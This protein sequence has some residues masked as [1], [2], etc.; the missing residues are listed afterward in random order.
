MAKVIALAAW[1][2]FTPVS[3]FAQEISDSL[4]SFS[5]A[6]P[7]AVIHVKPSE[8][9]YSPYNGQKI[10]FGII[11][12]NK[13]CYI[14]VKAALPAGAEYI[15]SIDNTSIDSVLLFRLTGNTWQA[16]YT[17]G[18]LVPYDRNRKYVWHTI[19]LSPVEGRTC[20]LAAFH[21]QGK[22]INVGYKIMKASDLDKRYAGFDRLI[23]FYMGGIFL[24]L[25]AVVYGWFVFRNTVLPYYALYIL[26]VTAWI[27]AHYGYLYPMLYPRFPV[28]NGI[29]KP[30]SISCG[31][32]FFSMLLR[33]LFRQ[34]L[35]KDEVSRS[36]LKYIMWLGVMMPV[37]LIAYLVLP[38]EAYMPA[39]FN[40]GWH[41]YFAV[42]F[43]CILLVLTR[44][45]EKDATARLFALAMGIMAA[46]AIQQVLSNAGFFY[47]YMLNE[48]GMLLASM[49]EILVLTF[50]TFRNIWEEKKRISMQ[51]VQLQ[52][53][54]S[55]ALEQLVTV[56][57]NERKRI[58]GEL[59]DSIGPM[60]AAIK[61]NFQRA[62]KAKAPN[63]PDALVA[64]TE[65][66]IDSSMA[67][68]RNISHQLMPKGL[69]AKG[70]AASLSEYIGNIREVYH[71]P[72]D[73]KHNITVA[74]PPDAQLNV[75]RI[76]SELT[77]N[78]AK[79]GRASCISVFLE[80][81]DGA[82]IATVA[83]DGRGFDPGQVNGSSLGLKNIASRVGYLKGTMQITS[84]AEKGTCIAI[85]IPQG[86]SG[87]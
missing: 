87:V 63:P 9:H 28:L 66:I 49:A 52:E 81:P 18:N 4:Y 34:M 67:E 10:D 15:L 39:L 19:P 60:L 20:I 56:Q 35:Q 8:L 75:Y 23:W 70:L 48:H 17:G 79:H 6:T 58:A 7:P 14:V 16:A 43:I 21:D 3:S 38:K 41:S 83:D 1:L 69:S 84:A 73:F 25:A 55:R 44:L 72:V 24:I 36:I 82:I 30:L 57:D 64:K 76:M 85:T 78:A 29:A 11:T 68:I 13:W 62:M 51:V 5:S 80:T 54:Y 42:S 59:H 47:N 37:T 86:D 33:T 71:V 74:L 31:L 53:E 45:F 12:H 61:I 27:L 2:C 32:L 77:L 65:D 46:M 22:N 26:S 40:V 50:A